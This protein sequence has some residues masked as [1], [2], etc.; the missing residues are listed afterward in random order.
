MKCGIRRQR[1]PNFQQPAKTKGWILQAGQRSSK[2]LRAQLHST[3]NR[4]FV[5]TRRNTMRR[6]LPSGLTLVFPFPD[7]L[8]AG[9]TRPNRPTNHNPLDC[10]EV[11]SG[12]CPEML[13]NKK[14]EWEYVGHDERAVLFC[15]NK[16][17]L[18]NSSLYR[19]TLP[20]DPPNL[21]SSTY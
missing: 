5:K 2:K 13:W 10:D 9:P 21:P 16:P 20:T 12:L 6:I 17:G 15:A 19:L 14:Y 11:N 3:A 1:K 8:D 18:G 4:I 7:D